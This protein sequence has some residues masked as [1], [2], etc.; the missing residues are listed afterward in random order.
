MVNPDVVPRWLMRRHSINDNYCKSSPVPVARPVSSVQSV[1]TRNSFVSVPTNVS[2][3]VVCRVPTVTRWQ[4][5]KKDVRPK[6]K[7]KSQIKCV[8]SASF[9]GHFVS[10]PNVPNVPNVASVQPVGGRLQSFWEIWA[11]KGAN[12]KVVSILK[13]GYVLPFKVRPPLV[14]D[15]LIVSGY[16]NPIRDSHL[17]AAVQ[18]LIEKKA[19]ER[20]RVQTSLA[21]FNRL[22]IVP[23]PNHKWRP[24]LDLSTLNQF[25]CV[26]TFKME[27][28]ETIRTSLQQEEWVTLL[29]FSDA[30]FHIPIHYTSRK[31]LRFHFQNQLYQFRA[32]PFGLSTAPMEFTGVVKEVKLMAQSQGIRIHQY[33]DDWLIQAPTKESCHQG[34]QSLLALCQELGWMVNMQKSELEPQQVFDFVG[35]QYDLLNGVVR[36]TQNRWET[37]QQKITVLLQNRSC[38]VRTFMSL[39]G[40]LTATEKQVT[41]GRL[42]MRPIQ[43]HLKKHWRVP[44]SLEKEIP[45]PRSLHQYLQWWTQEENVLKGQPLHPLRHA[46]Q[47]FTDASKEGWGAHLGDFTASGTWSVPESKLH[48]NFLEL[49][50]VLLALKRF[51]HLVQGKVVLIATDNT[52][53]VAYINKE[54]GMR[55]GSL[56]ALLWRL[57]CWCSLNQIVLKA[58][59]IPGRLNVIAD[60]LSR[61][62]QVI[63][64]EWSLHQETFDLLCQTWH[65]PRV[66]MFATRYNCKLVQFVSPI[67]DPKAW[68]VDALTLSWEDL[69]MYLFPPVSLMGKVVSKL[70]DHWYRRAI[71]IAPGWPNMPWFWDLVEL[72]ARVPLCLPHHPDLVTQPFNKARHRD[73]TNL[74]LHAWLLEPRQSR[75]KGS[76]AQ[77]RQELRRLKD[78]QPEQSTKRSGPFFVR[79]CETSQMDFRNPSI[80][81]IADFLLHLFQEKNLQPSTIDGYRSAIADKLGN[82]SVNVGKDENLTRLLDSFHRDRPKGRRGV[83]AWNLSLVLHQLTKAPF[84]PL[85]KASLKH[86]TFKT[87]FLLALASGKRRS[88]IHAWLNKNIRHQAD[89]SKVSLYPSPSFLAKNHLAKEGP[90]CVAPVV[91]PALAPTLDKSLKED[92]SLCPVRALRYYLDK[93]QD[94]R[95]GKELV[96]VSFKQGFNKDISPATISSWIKQTVVLC[97]DLSDQDSLTLHQVKAHDVRAFA[98]S[99]AFQGG[100]SLDQILAACHWKS[101]NTFT[102]FYLKDVAWADKEL[103]HLGPVV[104]AQQIHH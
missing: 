77:W 14:R 88:E 71:L 75:S 56:C 66:D 62:R 95:T 52:T 10:A 55:S 45:I 26:K 27:T 35:Y 82:T 40:L 74:N 51:Q 93:T 44:E 25:L 64:T 46:V 21:F 67:P 53:V 16:A 7:I 43:W 49:K 19:V 8:K 33:L 100:I 9:V 69:D 70:S 80:K 96:F 99:K 15:P 57:L 76:L 5:Q 39:I 83:P 12:P 36:P 13:E 48:I 23:K 84:E 79:W 87:V 34:T 60:K 32:L 29:D 50:A 11:H 103:F 30:Y 28:P 63:Q 18:A 38:R 90:E 58:R 22:F 72:S 68:S 20:V 91:I 65:Y 6:S 54:G 92:R 85:R 98:A 24:I 81:Q 31:F 17:Q 104:A 42:H 41:L 97:Y 61:Q 78:V 101:H 2:Y 3:H 4:S 73:L 94:L 59:H 47:I 102:Q 89:W 37:L 86:L 1:I